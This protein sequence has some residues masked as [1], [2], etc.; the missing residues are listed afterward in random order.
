MRTL[1][2]DVNRIARAGAKRRL[3]AFLFLYRKL[4]KSSKIVYNKIEIKNDMAK[5]RSEG[6]AMTLFMVFFVSW[7]GCTV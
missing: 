7:L 3:R 5:E 6:F 2:Y 1:Y 4:R